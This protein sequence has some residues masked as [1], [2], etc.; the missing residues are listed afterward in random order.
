VQAHFAEASA[1]RRQ[2]LPHHLQPGPPIRGIQGAA[3]E[4]GGDCAAGCGG[5]PGRARRE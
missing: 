4:H 2:V 3:T 1:E 5:E